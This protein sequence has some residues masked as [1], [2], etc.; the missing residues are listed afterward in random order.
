MFLETIKAEGLSHLSYLLGD[1]DAGVAAVID[2]RRDAQI[3]LDIAQKRHLRITHI[4]ETHI[5]A[6]FVS[7]SRELAAQTGAEVYVGNA[8]EYGF[9]HI[10]LH[11]GEE[12]ELESLTL[13]AI[14]TP[15]HT[16]EHISYL[17]RGGKG[18]QEPWA[19]FTGDTLFAG[20]VGRPDLL[21]EGS[22]RELAAALYRS[23]H[24][25]LL[26]LGDEVE[27]Y[28]AHGQ[29]SPCGGNIGDRNVSTIG[30]ERLHNPKLAAMSEAAFVDLVLSDLPP[31]PF[32]YPRMKKINAHGPELLRGLPHVPPIDPATFLEEMKKSHA[33]VV[34]TREIEAFGGGHIAGAL[35]IALRDE[36]PQWAGW[37]LPPEACILLV[38]SDE[39]KLDEAVRHLL[40][41]GYEHIVGFLRKGMRGWFEAGLP[42]ERT[43]QMSVQEL[44]VKLASGDRD[45]QL[46]DVR[47]DDEWNTGHIP[48]AQH[49]FAPYL[50]KCLHTIEK[51]RPVVIYCGSGYRASVAASV[52]QRNGFAHVSNVPGSM[53]A[54]KAAGYETVRAR[55]RP[56]GKF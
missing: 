43:G 13:K 24:E 7:G 16:P 30:Y 12:L 46:L 38:L 5:H 17:V 35:S 42:F 45:F 50:Q 20:E 6:D 2:P 31:A 18:S 26:A 9:P 11:G 36:F 49:V 47:R 55:L 3:Y 34:D 41:V 23:L 53:A 14:H 29:G 37:M 44:H 25:K 21:G 51:D 19:V 56:T 32:Y 1:A 33:V 40:R 48:T 54:W 4:L 28:P 27:I 22:E 10:A 39:A 52:L 15:G 8:G